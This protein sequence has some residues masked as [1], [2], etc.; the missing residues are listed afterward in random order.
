LGGCLK[1]DDFESL[2]ALST[3]PKFTFE[4][5]ILISD[6]DL[7]YGTSPTNRSL[8]SVSGFYGALRCFKYVLLNGCW[9]S[10]SVSEFSIKEGHLEIIGISEA[11]KGDFRS[12]LGGAVRYMR[13]D[14]ADWLLQ[15]FEVEEF[16]LADSIE[17]ANF[18]SILYL[19]RKGANVN[20][21]EKNGTT[22]LN[23]STEKGHL[24][25]CKL[26]IEYGAQI[27]AKN[28]FIIAFMISRVEEQSDSAPFC[29]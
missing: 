28:N 3:H 27:D 22:P 23:L 9:V 19:L 16:S 10:S 8:L 26:L 1:F 5:E 21:V 6:Y 13:N 2:Q 7:P 12:S 25:V 20:L 29:S 17:S 15:N 11:E 18:S 14:I 24:E 4:Q